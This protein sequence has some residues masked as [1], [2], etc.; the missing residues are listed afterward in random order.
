[1]GQLTLNIESC[2]FP[3]LEV[4]EDKIGGIK[5]P[6]GGVLLIPDAIEKDNTTTWTQ[7]YLIKNA[8]TA[9]LSGQIFITGDDADRFNIT[10]DSFGILSNGIV[11]LN[12]GVNVNNAGGQTFNAILTIESNNIINSCP[13]SMSVYVGFALEPPITSHNDVDLDRGGICA[14]T[15]I[16]SP[17]DF[18]YTD[19]NPIGRTHIQVKSLPAH[20]TLEYDNVLV[21]G[22]SL[23]LLI[24]EV[25]INKLVVH[26]DP[27]VLG[28]NIMFFYTDSSNNSGGTWSN[29]SALTIHI[30]P[31]ISI[32]TEVSVADEVYPP[33][34]GEG[35]Y[36]ASFDILNKEFIA[37]T[38]FDKEIV[39]T[40]IEQ[41]EITEVN[42]SAN[43]TASY[44]GSTIAVG[45][46][47]NFS[48]GAIQQIRSTEG[49]YTIDSY[50]KFKVKLFGSDSLTG[51]TKLSFTVN[52]CGC[53]IEYDILEIIY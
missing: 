23:P 49:I 47:I 3:I 36:P 38:F 16:C 50:F 21:T 12:I 8:G 10:P 51:E 44:N 42:Y 19:G 33:G 27:T 46:I 13:Y 52:A 45:N 18:P 11:Q 40:D 48:S 28:A 1:M 9:Q 17:S 6:C 37:L 24:A 39:S 43:H 7:N 29:E 25:D 32:K 34:C 22:G 2:S 30:N 4:W 53:E 41:I 31:C 14:A 5:V 15:H 26:S 35:T 20:G